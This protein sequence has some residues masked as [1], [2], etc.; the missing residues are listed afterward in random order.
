MEVN[1]NRWTT[2]FVVLLLLSFATMG[3]SGGGGNPVVPNTGDE[4]LLTNGATNP[5]RNPA[6]KDNKQ[7]WGFF[8]AYFD[9]V[10]GTFEVVPNHTVAGM[11]NAVNFYNANPQNFTTA[12]LSVTPSDPPGAYVNADIDVSLKH[13]FAGVP[14]FSGYDVHLVLI[15][16]QSA[17]LAHDGMTYGVPGVNVAMLDDPV[18]LD[19]GG[20]DGYTRWFNPTEFPTPGLLG[21]T[22]GKIAT[23]G[24]TGDATLSPYKLYVDGLTATGSAYDFIA[25]EG[26]PGN[27]IF[28]S[29][30]TPVARNMFI[31][32]PIGAAPVIK[33]NYAIIA[34]W[35]G[36]TAPA[37]TNSNAVMAADI[38]Q[39]DDVYYVGGFGGDL[40]LDI[41]LAGY[42]YQPS[43]IIV[44]SSV[45]TGAYTLDSLEMTPTTGGETWSTYHVEIPADAALTSSVGNDCWIIAEY[46]G[47]DL[48]KFGYQNTYGLSNGAGTDPLAAYFNFPVNVLDEIATPEDAKNIPLRDGLWAWDIAVDHSDGDL[49]VLYADGQIWKHENA[50]NYATGTLWADTLKPVYHHIDATLTG[51][52]MITTYRGLDPIQAEVRN[53]N[54]AIILG[55]NIAFPT[56]GGYPAGCLDAIGMI[57]GVY[58]NDVM[59]IS[60]WGLVNGDLVRARIFPDPFYSSYNWI[61]YNTT[62]S[63]AGLV[64]MA[65]LK[66]VEFTASAQCDHWMIEGAPEYSLEKYRVDPGAAGI[67]GWNYQGVAISG[68]SDTMTGFNAPVDVASD[69]TTRV[70]VLDVTSG[71][72]PRIKKYHW[73]GGAEG[74]YG[75]ATTIA[76]TPMRIE[77]ST[78]NG[79]IFV[80]SQD[81]LNRSYL[82]IFGDAEQAPD[83]TSFPP[84]ITAGVTGSGTPYLTGPETYTVTA[85]D[86][87]GDPLNYHWVVTN[88][89][90]TVVVDINTPNS[91]LSVDF[92]ALGGLVGQTWTIDCTVDD[93]VFFVPATQKSCLISAVTQI[94]NETFT[95]NAGGWV[96]NTYDDYGGGVVTTIGWTNTDGPFGA[97]A[98]ILRMPLTGVAGSGFNGYVYAYASPPIAVPGGLLSAFVRVNMALAN[99]NSDSCSWAYSRW[100]ICTDSTTTFTPPFAGSIATLPAGGAVL[101]PNAPNGYSAGCSGWEENAPFGTG[102]WPASIAGQTIDMPIPPAYWGGNIRIAFYLLQDWPTYQ[103]NTGF[104]IDDV[105]VYTTP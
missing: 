16:N 53:A 24:W 75:D 88:S 14:K 27:N 55:S 26:G 39:T 100:V 92:N 57:D 74:Y 68:L 25:G 49:Y 65:A 44:E 3:C 19:G 41:K 105:R 86:P 94:Y 104:A 13:P 83:V 58:T 97:A 37:P 87:D 56:A 1:M 70:H 30:N 81:G 23:P 33:I 51:T 20:P 32:F 90:P 2:L 82:S 47:A 28:A 9:T 76:Y 79:K 18:E 78:F 98:G 103:T 99:N 7:L 36:T 61:G 95:A 4:L 43:S 101:V 48:T 54:G 96:S 38:D 63:G 40:I 45:F 102:T 42:G 35:D 29:G 62:G 22:P 17:S 5:E 64:N 10:N 72:V 15:T 67:V 66:A 31:R 59:G 69:D 6:G 46:G 85:S 77:G 34:S 12:N 52:A 89:V 8:D 93:G 73:S 60:G 71:G 91:Y 21:Y 84:V 50:S 11:V 80:L